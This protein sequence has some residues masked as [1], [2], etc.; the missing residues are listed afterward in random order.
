MTKPNWIP[1]WIYRPF[2][3]IQILV[4]ISKCRVWELYVIDEPRRSMVRLVHM[5]AVIGYT[6]YAYKW[7]PKYD[8]E[9]TE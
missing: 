7:M 3:I 6:R 4:I 8:Y 5:A 2:G 9:I 1:F